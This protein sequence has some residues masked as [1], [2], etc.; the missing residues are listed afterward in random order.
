LV[1]WSST[2]NFGR[3]TCTVSKVVQKEEGGEM[4]PYLTIALGV[5]ALIICVGATYAW[6]KKW[7]KQKGESGDNNGNKKV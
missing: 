7:K 5:V 6:Y 3:S 2:Y 4:N 1:S